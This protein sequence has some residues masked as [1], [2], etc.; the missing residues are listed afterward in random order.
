M[1]ASG[2]FPSRAQIPGDGSRLQLCAEVL[3]Q[4]AHGQQ[5]VPGKDLGQSVGQIAGQAHAGTLLQMEGETQLFRDLAFESEPDVV[6]TFLGIAEQGFEKRVGF[7]GGNT[8]SR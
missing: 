2:D 6:G 4:F 5:R 1:Q 8:S 3:R 7:G